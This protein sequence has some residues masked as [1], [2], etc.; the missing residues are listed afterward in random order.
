MQ[1][2]HSGIEI[3]Y[4]ESKDVWRFDLRGR[5][6]SAATLSKAKEA[7][8]KEP[9][10]KRKQV[11]PRFEAYLVK[12]WETSVVTVTG[13]AEENY[14]STTCFWVTTKEGKRSKEYANILFPVSDH[15]TAILA[16]IKKLDD[17]I[18]ALEK[19][20]AAQHTKLQCATIPKELE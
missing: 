10:E 5:A 20:K 18:E 13:L 9:S 14:R 19:A 11:F 1:T 7:I 12:L 6:R 15:N 17:Q 2:T 3:E 16:E 4:D 8:D